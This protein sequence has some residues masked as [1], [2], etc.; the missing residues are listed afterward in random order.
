[1]EGFAHCV[2]RLREEMNFI[3]GKK[4]MDQ[5][6]SFLKC[7]QIKFRYFNQFRQ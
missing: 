6:S 1:M 3:A 4:I 2:V 5:K 7:G